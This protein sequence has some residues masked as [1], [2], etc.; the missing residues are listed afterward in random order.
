MNQERP[1]PAPLVTIGDWHRRCPYMTWQPADAES[2]ESFRSRAFPDEEAF[3]AAYEAVILDLTAPRELPDGNYSIFCDRGG[4]P[5]RTPGVT[6][7]LGNFIPENIHNT[8]F[9]VLCRSYGINPDHVRTGS[10]PVPDHRHI[11]KI[12]WDPAMAALILQVGS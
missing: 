2:Y 8:A 7:R 6:V 5:S 3:A 4:T 12:T 10:H 11:E 9:E 1:Q